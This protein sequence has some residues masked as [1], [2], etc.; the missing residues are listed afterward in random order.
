MPETDD[1]R[2]LKHAYLLHQRGSLKEAAV[3]YRKLISKNPD[4]FHA[5]HFLGIVEAYF[6]NFEQA[7]LA[8]ARSVAIQ[9]PNIQ[10]TENYAAILCESKN[11]EHALQVCREGL[12]LNSVSAS[13]L[14][15]SATSLFKLGQLQESLDQFDKLLLLQPNH[16][17]ALNERGSV[18]GAM[19]EADAALVSI[20]KALVLD[21]NHAEAHLHRGNLCGELKRY[22]EAI[23]SY[24]KA[25]A[26]RPNLAAACLGR[27]N[28]FRALN[29]RDEALAAYDK[30]LVLSSGFAEAW[31]GRAN[32][33]WEL[34]R[35]D[36]A[37]ASY[38]KALGLRP[39]LVDAW[40]GRGNICN[41]LARYDD[42]LTAYD[43]VVALRP[44]F[45]EAWLGRGSSLLKLKRHGEAEAAVA[46][47]LTLKPELAEAWLCRGYVLL[48]L[49][50]LTDALAAFDKAL[51]IRSDFSE[52]ISGRIFVLELLDDAGFEEQQKARKGWWQQVGAP[53]AAQSRVHYSSSRDP[54]GRIRVGY[55]SAD[56]QKHSAALSFRPV[57][58]N[59]DKSQF[60]VTCYSS[61]RVQDELTQD[62]RG[63]AD[64][65]RDVTRVSDDELSALIQADQ[66]DILVDLSGHSSNNR[67]GVFARKPAPVQVTAWGYATGTGLPTID[68]LFSDPVACPAPIRHNFAEKIF[69]LPCLVT[70]DPLLDHV[71]PSNPPVLSK[72]YVTFGVFNR[73]SKISDDVLA[74][75]ARVLDSVPQSRILLK[76]MAFEDASL[77][78]RFS[79]SFAARGIVASRVA[80]LGA[81]LRR[82]HLAAFSEIDIS[83]DPFPHNGGISTWE[84]LQM[85][86][87][88]VAKLGDSIPS[89]VAGAILTAVGMA[90]WV[91]D[92]VDGYVAIAVKLAAM[93]DHLKALRY[94]LP[95]RILASAAGNSATYTKAVEAAYRTMWV[96]YCRAAAGQ[97]SIV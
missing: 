21:P 81:T 38:D 6:G 26:L 14:Y 53:I 15:V 19:K 2:Q 25:L 95:A 34:K 55:V 59:H 80:F 74:V 7:K 39:D 70:I 76:S 3:I 36:E 86:V 61:S 57:L 13:L 31:I 48:E 58:L 54:G 60:E 51:S 5:L 96:D 30:A 27:G 8:M 69:D 10:F 29:R 16:V 56:F 66:I 23:A 37:L 90:D 77:R 83:L 91:S 1:D 47:A 92:D 68:Y 82:D 12:Q 93:P 64:R 63:A 22:E 33:C 42:A 97:I 18:L 72:G 65:W 73:A 50:S 89:R 24:D 28:V 88:V 46:R 45:A 94:E 75:W 41:E 79:E 44:E 87:P 9:P 17:I 52:A 84:S 4:N 32:V 71:P 20:D 62:F 11:Y 78:N 35:Y 49:N 85:G 43:R 67:L 40:L